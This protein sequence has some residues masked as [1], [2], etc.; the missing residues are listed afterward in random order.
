MNL[1][2]FTDFLFADEQDADSTF[3]VLF[4]LLQTVHGRTTSDHV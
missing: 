2:A 3:C 4:D 1:L